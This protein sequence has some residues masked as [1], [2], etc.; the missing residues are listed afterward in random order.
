MCASKKH[1]LNLVQPINFDYT[2]QCPIDEWNDI[3]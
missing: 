2:H 3:V 1:G